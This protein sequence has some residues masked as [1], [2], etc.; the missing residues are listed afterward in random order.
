M[1]E[2]KG[3][4]SA[5]C[6][7]CMFWKGDTWILAYVDD[8]V[9]IAVNHSSIATVI[10][11]LKEELDI[12]PLGD[13]RLFLGFSFIRDADG[14]WLH[15][16]QYI[17][18]ILDRFCMEKCEPVTAPMTNVKDATVDND[19]TCVEQRLYQEMIGALLYLSPDI[20]S[21]VSRLCRYSSEPRAKHMTAVKRVFR[22]LQG[23]KR[24]GLILSIDHSPTFEA[25]A[26]SNWAGDRADRKPTNGFILRYGSIPVS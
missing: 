22:Y 13:L 10:H 20:S 5:R 8:I 26:D 18:R 17:N 19:N 24:Y 11:H 2:T 1:L 12:K 21:A 6:D 23:T 14:A 4:K 7:E 15:Q 3:F 16:H 9:V 25:Y